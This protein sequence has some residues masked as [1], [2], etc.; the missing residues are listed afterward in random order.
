MC[1]V[2]AGLFQGRV[3]PERVDQALASISHRGP[4][5]TN[6][7]ISDDGRWLL[8]HTRLSIIG[9]DNGTQPIAN[10]SGDVRIVVNGEFYG[11]QSIRERLRNDGWQFSTESDS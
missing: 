11:Y 9:L 7:W 10:Q 1:G 8:G 2:L 6:K 4:D 3:N 5:F